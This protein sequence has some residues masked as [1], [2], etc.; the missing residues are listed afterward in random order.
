MKIEIRKPV[1]VSLEAL[2]PQQRNTIVC[3]YALDGG[4]KRTLQEIADE[5]SLTRERIRQVQNNALVKLRKGPCT[6]LLVPVLEHLEGALRSCGG[7]ALEGNLYKLCDVTEKV[8]QNYIHLL[9]T[10]GGAFCQSPGMDDT[11]EYWY[12]EEGHKKA[13]DGMINDIHKELAKRKRVF[14]R[15]DLAEFF[16]ALEKKHGKIELSHDDLMSISR[17]VGRNPHGEWGQ[18]HDPEVSLN[19]LSGYIRLVLREAAGEPLSF[20]EVAKRVSA[21]K[22][23]SCHEGS[24]HNE[25]VRQKEFI[26]VGRGLYVLE[27]M[28]YRSG[29]VTDIA[30]ALI[31]EHGP[32][33]MAELIERVKKER[34]VKDQS[35]VQ[36]LLNKKVFTKDAEKRYFLI[37]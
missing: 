4:K 17:R 37:K 12:I 6:D 34:F 23:S 9:L 16:A 31:K 26:L 7:I 27:G 10:L 21:M 30:V 33:K 2:T 36:A 8:D 35:I 28:G 24:C 25:L 14:S 5:Y 29:T 18:K 1:D 11:E 19:R 15:E 20:G 32:M 3:R 22:G 13:V